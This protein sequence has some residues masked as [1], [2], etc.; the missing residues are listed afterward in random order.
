MA[1]QKNHLFGGFFV[2]IISCFVGGKLFH[3]AVD[4]F[5]H[6]ANESAF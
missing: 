5:I 1:A 2:F 4:I 6:M 3:Q